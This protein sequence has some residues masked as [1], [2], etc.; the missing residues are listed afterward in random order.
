M[1]A[2][3]EAYTAPA[4]SGKLYKVARGD[5]AS[6]I[7][8]KHGVTLQQLAATNGL[9]RPYVVHVGRK[10][11]IPLAPG[12]RMPAPEPVTPDPPSPVSPMAPQPVESDI[13]VAT[14]APVTSTVEP[15]RATVPE[16]QAPPEVRL[17]SRSETIANEV[18][19]VKLPTNNPGDMARASAKKPPSLSGDGFLWPTSG[20]V[21]SRYGTKK[22]GSQN[23]GINIAARLG[24]PVLA[25]ENG[26]VSYASDEIVGWG[27]MVLVRHADGFTTGYAHLDFDPDPCRRPGSSRPG[28]R[29]GR[30]DRLRGRAAAA[31][32]AALRQAGAGS[33]QA[34]DQG[35]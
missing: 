15:E 32:R 4:Y 14:L 23:D 20:S 7:A 19:P 18:V 26:I 12:Q 21:V 2:K 8:A 24:T 35:R 6:T 17:K 31:F 29:T 34:A 25:A 10:L 22:D 33:E 5:T 11:K 9:S 30:P 1:A 28:D 13:Q 3:R 16:P 27:R